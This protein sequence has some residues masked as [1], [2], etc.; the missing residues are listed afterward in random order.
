MIVNDAIIEMRNKMKKNE[1]FALLR[2]ALSR[3]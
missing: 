2:T 3:E 1:K